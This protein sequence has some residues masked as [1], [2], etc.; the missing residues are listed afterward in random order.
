MVK[1]ALSKSD[2]TQLSALRLSGYCGWSSAQVFI[3]SVTFQADF[4][5]LPSLSNYD[6]HLP[7]YLST[8]QT[9]DLSMDVLHYTSSIMSFRKDKYNPL[10]HNSKT[11]HR[12]YYQTPRDVQKGLKKKHRMLRHSLGRPRVH[13]GP[14]QK[15]WGPDKQHRGWSRE[16][17]LVCR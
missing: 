2:S 13:P 11:W 14:H 15:S 8:I 1:I 10:R 6:G 12:G 9:G 5:C 4:R 16:A 17:P 7:E 3:S